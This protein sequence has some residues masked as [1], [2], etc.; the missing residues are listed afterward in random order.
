MKKKIEFW[1]LEQSQGD[2]KLCFNILDHLEQRCKKT[3]KY[4]MKIQK[5][6]IFLQIFLTFFLENEKIFRFLDS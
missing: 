5:W 1:K 4:S 6:P 2:L 3:L